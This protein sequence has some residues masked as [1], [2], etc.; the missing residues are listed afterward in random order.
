MLC[1]KSRGKGAIFCK[2]PAAPG[3]SMCEPHM[4]RQRQYQR[5]YVA[6]RKLRPESPPEPR[7]GNCTRCATNDRMTDSLVCWVCMESPFP[8]QPV[9]K[10]RRNRPHRRVH[11]A[12]VEKKTRAGGGS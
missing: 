1:K 3:K 9:K 6:R 4:E 10:R 5:D 8:L 2:T 11:I 12:T 7:I